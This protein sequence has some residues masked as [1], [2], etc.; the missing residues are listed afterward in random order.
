MSF[1]LAYQADAVHTMFHK[2]HVTK[3]NLES[4][5]I[6]RKKSTMPAPP[7]RKAKASNESTVIPGSE[8]ERSNRASANLKRKYK[9]IWDKTRENSPDDFVVP[10]D[11]GSCFSC[12]GDS[13]HPAPFCR[14]LM[15]AII[16]KDPSLVQRV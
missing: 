1:Q 12:N 4:T 3:L 8:Q 14:R 9:K 6:Q 7:A 13:K 2:S 5:R 11:Y 10:Y 15:V 16:E